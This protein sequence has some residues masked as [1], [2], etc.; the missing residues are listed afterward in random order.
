MGVFIVVVMVL[1]VV[2]VLDLEIRFGLSECFDP[3]TESWVTQ[4][5]EET[6]EDEDENDYDYSA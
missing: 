6:L 4:A 2:L 3:A 5:L 1:V